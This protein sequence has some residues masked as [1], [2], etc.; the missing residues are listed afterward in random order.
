MELVA[1][2]G[3][4]AGHWGQLSALLNRFEC[5]R[6]VLVV[7]KGVA[8]YPTNEKTRVVEV[9]SSLPLQKLKDSIEEKLKKE[10]DG[11]F[12]VAV[13][14]ASGSGKEHMALLAALLSIPVGIKLIAY[15]KEGV[16]F[17]S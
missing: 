13:S 7:Q 8:G 4:D 12:E 14:L 15:T 11:A 5:E 9:D 10:I 6:I 16:I 1:F 3:E 17:L 2:V